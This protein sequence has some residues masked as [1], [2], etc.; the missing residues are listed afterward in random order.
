MNTGEDAQGLRKIVDLTRLISM[1]I[2]GLHFYICCYAAFDDWGWTAD[3][4]DKLIKNIAKT[5]LFTDLLKA[6]LA[7][8]LFLGITVLAA[9]GKKDEKIQKKSPINET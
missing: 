7:A 9:K 6:K 3:I 5:G 2:L 4:T 1:A 8:L